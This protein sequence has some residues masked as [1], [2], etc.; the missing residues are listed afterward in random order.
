M[1]KLGGGGDHLGKDRGRPL[2]QAE[3]VDT[4][5]SVGGE[6]RAVSS[7]YSLLRSKTPRFHLCF[8]PWPPTADWGAVITVCAVEDCE[9][10]DH[11]VHLFCP[12]PW[13][14]QDKRMRTDGLREGAASSLLC[15]SGLVSQS[16]LLCWEEGLLAV[17]FTPEST[18]SLLPSDG[19]S[20][21][22]QV[23]SPFLSAGPAVLLKAPSLYLDP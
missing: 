16:F 9:H 21:S 14:K 2:R 6:Q 17:L 5:D 7:L 1:A 8:L 19:F 13:G 22:F 15:V 10:R 12:P 4:G 23:C 11:G 3:V 18:P 20:T